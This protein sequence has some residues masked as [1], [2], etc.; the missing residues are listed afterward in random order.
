MNVEKILQQKGRNVA[1]AE[2]TA[3][4]L[5][6]VKLLTSRKIGAVVVVEEGDQVA[7]IISERDIVR[8]ISEAGEKGLSG[9]AR[10]YMTSRVITCAKEDTV[11]E[12]MS[13]MTAGRFRHLPVVEDGRLVG[14]VSIGD[15]VKQRIAEAEQEAQAMRE[16]IA[17]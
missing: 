16:Y 3:T 8:A 2:T 4:L 7:G 14:I 6:I 13:S 10:D 12:L 9:I 11:A 17:S 5:D 1:T 15:V